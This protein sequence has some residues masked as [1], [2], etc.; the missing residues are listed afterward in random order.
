[1]EAVRRMAPKKPGR[2]L[3]CGSGKRRTFLGISDIHVVCLKVL[4]QEGVDLHLE[5]G[6]LVRDGGCVVTQ[7]Y[8]SA[9]AS[10][11]DPTLWRISRRCT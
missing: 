1:L 2:Q 7:D 5:V 8:T 3:A 4:L 10:A 11:F 9:C 6:H